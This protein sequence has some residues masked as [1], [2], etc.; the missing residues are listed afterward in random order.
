[1]HFTLRQLQVFATVA[2]CG[3]F[4]RAAEDLCLTQP[5][6]S[7]QI[8]QLTDAVGL[9]LLEQIGRKVHLTEAG[10]KLYAR[11]QTMQAEWRAFEDEVS[12]LKGLQSGTLRLAVVSTVKYFVPRLLT[13]FCTRYPG[14][15]VKLV[16]ANL[17]QIVERM[18]GNL[19]DLYI[20]S[21]P[22]A[23]L[24]LTVQAFLD[25][26]LVMIAPRDHPLAKSRAIP[27]SRLADERFILREAGSGTRVAIERH[28]AQRNAKLNVRME[29]GSNLAIKE[30][31]AAGLGLSI[32]SEYALHRSKGWSDDVAILDVEDFPIHSTWQLVHLRQKQLS[33]VARAFLKHVGDEVDAEAI[34]QHGETARSA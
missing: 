15:E 14:I 12:E 20:L 4:T 5:A 2:D 26:P 27:L 11:W 10:R 18:Q 22:P 1:M 25:N 3:N 23:E 6:V 19:D 8:R 13:P 34:G 16:V 30:A 17:D 7:Q 28:L 29:F 9:L 32:L 33:A 24:D 31:V 21:A